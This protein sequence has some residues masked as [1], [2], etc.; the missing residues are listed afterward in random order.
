[1]NAIDILQHELAL[2]DAMH[3]THTPGSR[4]HTARAAVRHIYVEQAQQI[5]LRRSL[6]GLARALT[7]GKP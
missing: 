6:A 1:M 5:I 3:A 7:G 4:S 2:F